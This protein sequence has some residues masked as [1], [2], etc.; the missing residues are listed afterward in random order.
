[1]LGIYQ[2]TIQNHI[3]FYDYVIK[4]VS[5]DGFHFTLGLSLR[6]FYFGALSA[7]YQYRAFRWTRCHNLQNR[8]IDAKEF[9]TQLLYYFSKSDNK[10]NQHLSWISLFDNLPKRG[11]GGYLIN[12]VSTSSTRANRASSKTTRHSSWNYP[13]NINHTTNLAN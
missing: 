8:A 3:M 10:S 7:W 11:G 2:S 1:M 4:I 12:K 13:S 5:P 6:G 9:Q